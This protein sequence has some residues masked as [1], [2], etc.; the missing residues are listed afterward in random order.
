MV[1]VVV[2]GDDDDEQAKG[3]TPRV[4][5]VKSIKMAL[6]PFVSVYVV[7]VVYLNRE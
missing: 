2:V 7:V 3:A 4:W 6:L 1:V 5:L